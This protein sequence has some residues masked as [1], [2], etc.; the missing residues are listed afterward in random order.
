MLVYLVSSTPATAQVLV[1]LQRGLYF[2]C[3]AISNFEER[4]R[5]CLRCLNLTDIV[6]GTISLLNNQLVKIT[7]VSCMHCL[8]LTVICSL[9]FKVTSL[10]FSQVV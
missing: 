1:C 6:D 7:D 8:R 9:P 4:A 5:F 10:T 2:M 3:S